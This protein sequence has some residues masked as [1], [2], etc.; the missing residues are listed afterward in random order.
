MYDMVNGNNP[1]TQ[2]DKLVKR[3]APYMMG[4][5]VI[6]LDGSSKLTEAQVLA[7]DSALKTTSSQPPIMGRA[8]V[9]VVVVVVVVAAK[10]VGVVIL[11]GLCT[12]DNR[13]DTCFDDAKAFTPPST[14]VNTRRSNS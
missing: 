5:D 3:P 10:E 9:V 12:A 1:H 4:N 11:V 14:V 13:K 8:V 7:T 2:G 6:K